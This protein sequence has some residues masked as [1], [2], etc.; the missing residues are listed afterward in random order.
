MLPPHLQIFAS[1]HTD[2]GCGSASPSAPPANGNTAVLCSTWLPQVVGGAER[3]GE[4][5][6]EPMEVPT[7]SWVSRGWLSTASNCS[8]GQTGRPRQLQGAK[9]TAHKSSYSRCDSPNTWEAGRCLRA[10]RQAPGALPGR[11]A[12]VQRP[13][14]RRARS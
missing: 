1:T 8:H 4:E 6:R 12:G 7:E 5:G 3:G 13:R 11:R 14:E 2:K 10:G 9:F